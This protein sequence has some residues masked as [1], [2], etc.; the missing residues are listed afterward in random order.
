MNEHRVNPAESA[1]LLHAVFPNYPDLRGMNPVPEVGAFLLSL[2]S[3]R[4]KPLRHYTGVQQPE[5]QLPNPS[6]SGNERARRDCTLV[7][8]GH[9]TARHADV[10]HPLNAHFGR[11][12]EKQRYDT[13]NVLHNPAHP[14]FPHEAEYDLCE[15]KGNGACRRAATRRRR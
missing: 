2:R 8:G 6:G 9:V 3:E 14:L 4:P 11:N 12:N 7:S 1:A 5:R 10:A 13:R 15:R